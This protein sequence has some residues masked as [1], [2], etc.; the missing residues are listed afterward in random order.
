MQKPTKPT[1]AHQVDAGCVAL[2]IAVLALSCD[3]ERRMLNWIR[4]LGRDGHCTVACSLVVSYGTAFDR[5]REARIPTLFAD[6]ELTDRAVRQVPAPFNDA[7]TLFWLDDAR[8]SLRELARVLGCSHH[9]AP[10]RTVHAHE[11]LLSRMRQIEAIAHA[12]Q[13]RDAV[14][15]QHP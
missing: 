3:L 6:A 2:R 12:R 1:E 4:W 14:V 7:I 9:T 8:P 15:L 11:L 5:N 10:S 13:R